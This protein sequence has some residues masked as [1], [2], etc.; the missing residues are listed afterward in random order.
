MSR[1]RKGRLARAT[2]G[3]SSAEEEPGRSERVNRVR[4]GSPEEVRVRDAL[5]LPA[6]R[7]REVRLLRA[8]LSTGSF[9]AGQ[10][11]DSTSR[12]TRWTC[13]QNAENGPCNPNVNTS[14]TGEPSRGLGSVTETFRV[15]AFARSDQ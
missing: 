12:S 4:N 11:S 6:V 8:A 7:G 1:A 15:H 5:P 13:W 10:R 14:S 9:H 3:W 2:P